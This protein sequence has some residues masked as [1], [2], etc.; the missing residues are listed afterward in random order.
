M[1]KPIKPLTKE[2][3]AYV[4]DGCGTASRVPMFIHFWVHPESFGDRKTAVLDL[5]SRYPQD[6]QIIWVN[7][8]ETFESPPDDP[9]YRWANRSASM[10]QEEKSIALDS[11]IAIND[12]SELDDIIEH[13]P[14]PHYPG[15]FQNNPPNDGRYR[16]AWWWFCFFERHWSLRGMSNALMDYYIAPEQ[17]HRLFRKLTD[18]YLVLIERAK[19]EIGADAILTGDDLGTQRS[20]FFSL[21]FFREFF[22]PYYKELFDRAHELGMHF[23]FHS[24][25]N[26]ETFIPEWIEIGLDVLHPIQRHAMDAV[27]IAN[28][29][30]GNITI[31]AGADVQQVIP[32]GT[33]EDVRKEVRY[34]IDTYYRPNGKLILGAGNGINED[35][36]LENLEAFL[37]ESY[38]YG[39]KKMSG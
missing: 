26:V 33:T 2:E 30:G 14:N 18:F 13:F 22:K 1:I 24:C 8:P 11:Q 20:T 35:C 25:G 29:Y 6:G 16:I 9:D 37:H 28:L 15:M 12:W 4:I 36:P 32:F 23:W 39:S 38:V 10:P 21:E 27:R 19:F 7:I 17:V 31:W 5:L 3:I 34:L